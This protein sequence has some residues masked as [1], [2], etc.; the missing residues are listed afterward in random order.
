MTTKAQ[1]NTENAPAGIT[2]VR[3]TR[4]RYL[5]LVLLCSLACLTY[6][7]RIC[8]MRVQGEIERDLDFDRLSARDEQALA[9]K[10]L[11][12]DSEARAKLAQDRATERMSWVFSAFVL[13]YVLFG[14]P[15]GWLADRFRPRAIILLIV[16]WWSLFTALTGGVRALAGLGFPRPE[17]WVL[18]GTM[19]L[20][21]FLFGLGEAGAYPN[22]ARA[23]GRWFPF[24]ERGAA[25]GAIWL[26]SRLGGAVAPTL[27]GSLVGVAGGW[28]RAF[29]IL[30]A[31]GMLWALLFFLWFR[32]RPEEKASAN[33]AE[34]ALI[35]AGAAEPES[36]YQDE[37]PAQV[38][39]A[40][41]FLSSNLLWLYVA[42]FT[43]NLS[44]FFYVTFLPKYLKDQF[45]VDYSH[46][47]IMTGLPL[48]VGGLACLAGGRLSDV[49]IRSTGSKRWGRS[50]QGAIGLGVAAACALAVSRANSPWPVILIICIA[51]AFQ[52]LALPAMWS[53]SVDIGGRCAGTV[54][55]CM[56]SVGAIGAM[57]SPL[58]A[59]KVASL[60]NWKAVFV[61]F[62]ASYFLG[63]LAWL[64]VD[65]SRP[66]LQPGHL[67]R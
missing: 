48:L 17:P 38:P 8:I 45:H 46:S 22:V 1:P 37:A 28:Q 51:S 14:L 50:L 62:A 35:R 61:V 39:W 30:G 49:L 9:A 54:G 29:W 64:R 65:A 6:L 7:D 10:G 66:F 3:P 15:G 18:V 43:A 13:G 56:N 60:W 36:I 63:A 11:A 59:A 21:R 31:A 41:L 33:Q 5:V 23:L 32:D 57:L 27:I 12:N 40:R 47:E 67:T 24:R 44:W 26:S 20:V 4:V 55:G 25:Q 16:L 58:V 19:V 52:D 42:S 2:G 53:A 34:C